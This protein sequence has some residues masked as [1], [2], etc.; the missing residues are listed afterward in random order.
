MRLDRAHARGTRLQLAFALLLAM[1]VGFVGSLQLQAERSESVDHADSGM[2]G[3]AV[4]RGDQDALPTG[5]PIFEGE[6][7]RV[8]N[9]REAETDKAMF[10]DEARVDLSP[11]SIG[12]P[13]P[14]GPPPVL[15]GRVIVERVG[16]R[17]P[18]IG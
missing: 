6:A 7:E 15:R 16:A 8:E 3:M 10:E 5:K 2:V 9:E 4:E 14:L 12:L 17:G 13:W 1:V 11:A 18:P